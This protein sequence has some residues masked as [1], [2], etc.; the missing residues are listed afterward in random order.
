M[1]ET[2][3]AKT[4][5]FA[6]QVKRAE[7]LPVLLRQFYEAQIHTGSCSIFAPPL[8]SLP[9][10][11]SQ[12]RAGY[13][14]MLFD[15]RLLIAIDRSNYLIR[16]MNIPFDGH[17]RRDGPGLTLLLDEDRFRPPYMRGDQDSVQYSRFQLIQAS[18]GHHSA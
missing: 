13:L 2:A 4:D 12:P 9:P 7:Q 1:H 8:T 16:T 14:I 5:R 6:F 10:R 3:T 11:H 15:H 17:L 18:A